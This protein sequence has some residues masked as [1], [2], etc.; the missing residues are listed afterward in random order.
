MKRI[1]Q[2][3]LILIAL[4][5]V[6]GAML[7]LAAAL[8]TLQM[9]PGKPI[10]L[11]SFRP[12]IGQGVSGDGLMRG[13]VT[14]L[15]ILLFI[16]WGLVPFYIIYLIISPEARKQLVRD[17]AR[18]LPI[19]LLLW[20]LLGNKQGQQMFRNLDLQFQPGNPLE[21]YPA[22]ETEPLEFNA[23]PPDWI[24]TVTSV[25]I[26]FAVTGLLVGLVYLVW[27]NRVRRL[28]EL[29]PLEEIAR[30]AQDAI[31][32]IQAGGDLRDVIMRCY[33]EMSR[34]VAESRNLHRGQDMTPHEFE[35]FLQGRGLPREAIHQITTLFEAVRYGGFTPGRQEENQAISSLNAI[36]NAC[37]RP[38]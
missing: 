23:N 3:T 25:V 2:R 38:S 32:A 26:A 27:R 16:I 19:L 9:A 20:F 21:A 4:G 13:F 1:D 10:P 31:H 11:E 7:L 30:E 34:V 12:D 8:P 35:V 29:K 33:A 24:V 17:L 28:A 15:R 5:V 18:L 14:V 37:R 22:P 6:L 36:V